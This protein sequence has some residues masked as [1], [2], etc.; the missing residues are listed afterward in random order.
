MTQFALL[1]KEFPLDE[2]A[3]KKLL[4]EAKERFD[5]DD[6]L[7]QQKKLV[8]ERL[9]LIRRY[10]GAPGRLYRI[11]HGEIRGGFQWKPAGPVYHVP[12]S[13][14]KELA[15]KRKKEAG[16]LTY[17]V[18]PRMRRTVWVGGIRRFEKEGLVFESKETPVIFGHECLEWIDP[19]PAPDNSDMRIDS[20]REEDG[21]YVDVK[22]HTDGFRL[23]A[24]RARVE[25]SQDVVNICPIPQ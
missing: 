15:E 2:N 20:K 1:E 8:D 13:L 23:E 5:Y 17:A 18:P 19:D 3:E 21:V 14:E 9:D 4:G 25:R 24:K 16:S 7:A 22:I 12:E 10:I 11:H 6:L